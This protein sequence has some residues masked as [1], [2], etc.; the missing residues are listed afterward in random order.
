MM[1]DEIC[2]MK[3]VL[4]EYEQDIEEKDDLILNL[5]EEI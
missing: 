4:M 1:E 5:Q 2:R 3:N